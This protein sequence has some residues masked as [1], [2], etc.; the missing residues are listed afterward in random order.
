MK[1]LKKTDI[2]NFT[3]IVNHAMQLLKNREKQMLSEKYII[4]ID[5]NTCKWAIEQAIINRSSNK[6]MIE[7]ALEYVEKIEHQL[8]SF[9]NI[10]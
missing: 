8:E 3:S 5:I 9:N 7:A 10:N 6:N 2:N 4:N 1:Q